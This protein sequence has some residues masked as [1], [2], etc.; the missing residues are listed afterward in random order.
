MYCSS[1]NCIVS[2]FFFSLLIFTDIYMIK[3]IG[4][5]YVSVRLTVVHHEETSDPILAPEPQVVDPL[6]WTDLAAGWFFFVFFLNSDIWWRTPISDWV[7][8]ASNKVVWGGG[9]VRDYFYLRSQFSGVPEHEIWLLN[10]APSHLHLAQQ[11]RVYN[12]WSR[13]LFYFFIFS[14][15]YSSSL[16]LNFES[17]P[18]PRNHRHLLHYSRR[19]Q[20]FKNSLEWS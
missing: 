17:T 15:S 20:I 4:V 8:W 14:S 13:K 6:V 7:E 3:N 19:R 18:R 1:T 11:V 5:N 10:S 2:E 9:R 16:L 12:R